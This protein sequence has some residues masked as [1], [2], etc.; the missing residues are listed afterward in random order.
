ME[1]RTPPSDVDALVA[2]LPDAFDFASGVTSDEERAAY[3][4]LTWDGS[5]FGNG[6]QPMT[7][8]LQP[9]QLFQGSGTAQELLQ[10]PTST[11]VQMWAFDHRG[12]PLD[13]GAVAAWWNLQA[14]TAH[15][16]PVGRRRRPAHRAGRERAHVPPR[17][18]ARGTTRR[19]DEQVAAH[20]RHRQRRRTAGE[21]Q[22]R[23]HRG[24]HERAEPRRL[25]AAA[26][27]GPARRSLHQPGPGL[28]ERR[29]G[30][31]GAGLR[32]DRRA[33]GRARPRRA[34]AD[35]RGGRG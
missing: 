11:S 33:V 28:A 21:Q 15:H 6:P 19:A 5:T 25:P 20:E 24:V 31:S 18:R 9:G 27:R 34:A 17:Q 29:I 26:R 32:A 10:F 4:G 7:D 22:Q 2:L 16:E 13:P 3:L 23:R 8:L 30:Q 12:R 14:G 1:L 35:R